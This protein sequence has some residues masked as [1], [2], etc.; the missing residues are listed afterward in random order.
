MRV[1]VKHF[2]QLQQSAEPRT[3]FVDLAQDGIVD[4][5]L[6]ILD[7][8]QEEVG[9]LVING[10]EA[11]WGQSLKENDVVTLIPHIGGG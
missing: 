11:I 3:R 7:L 9:I 4:D 10:K 8:K 5:L 2:F 1:T 6:P